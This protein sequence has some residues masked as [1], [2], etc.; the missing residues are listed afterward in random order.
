MSAVS[1]SSRTSSRRAISRGG[2]LPS[3][4][5]MRIQGCAA[6]RMPVFSAAPRNVKG[7]YSRLVDSVVVAKGC[8]E[9]EMARLL[10][11]MYRHI[12][13]AL[14]NEML[15]FSNELRSTLGRHALCTDETLRVP[16][17]PPRA[18]RGRPLHPDR[19]RLTATPRARPARLPFRFVE[20]G[21]RDQSLYARVRRLLDPTFWLIAESD[22]RPS[23]DQ[24]EVGNRDGI[25]RRAS[26]AE[27]E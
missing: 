10:E 20:L 18:R 6:C 5:M 27:P 17:V 4:S 8:R 12:N 21:S 3:A 25:D 9:A 13:I 23:Q 26:D 11:S 15:K 22:C 14:V 19:P 2:Q 1:S 7:F 24:H 16:V